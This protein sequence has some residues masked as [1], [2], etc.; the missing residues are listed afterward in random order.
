MLSK[1]LPLCALAFD[2]NTV[3]SET[4]VKGNVVVSIVMVV[5]VIFFFFCGAKNPNPS[6]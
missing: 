5:V 6:E 3:S 4:V 1:I 2:S